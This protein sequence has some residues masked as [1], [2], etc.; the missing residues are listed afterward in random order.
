[1][2]PD[3]NNH[4]ILP[5]L[6]T[7]RLFLTLLQPGMEQAMVDFLV[8]NR[9]HFIAWD[10]PAP[11]GQGTVQYWRSQTLKSLME[12]QSGSAERFVLSL[13]DD[14]GHIIGVTNFSQIARG[15]FQAAILGYKIAA[16][17]EG[18]GLMHEALQSAIG[19]VFNKLR[20]H[21]I[22]ANYIPSNVRSGRLLARLGFAI[23]G[24]AKDYLFINGAWR[25]HILTALTNQHFETK[26]LVPDS[27]ASSIS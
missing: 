21:R 10:P 11:E 22:Q 7:E 23:E 4:V 8:A 18:K 1:L 14:P 15:P 24:Y 20:L 2:Q 17:D 27:Q 19:Y 26:W 25:D 13:R 16:S 5:R 12:F 6:E 3:S 9:G